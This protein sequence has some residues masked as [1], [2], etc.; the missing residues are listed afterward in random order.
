VAYRI[1]QLKLTGILDQAV[2]IVKDNFGLLFT[3][4]AICWI[5]LQLLSGIIALTMVPTFDGQPT[6]EQ[7]RA[8]DPAQMMIF[9]VV[10]MVLGLVQG[11]IALPLMNAA[12]IY[13]VA[14]KYLGREV[15]AGDALRKGLTKIAPLIGTAIL[16]YLAVFGGLILL[17]IPGILFA[18]WF[19]LSQHT[20]VLENLSGTR[21]LSRSKEL[22]RPNMGTFLMLGILVFVIS[23]L[24]GAGSQMIPQKF[25]AMIVNVLVTSAITLFSIAVFV[26][27]YFSCRCAVENFDLEHLA[28]LIDSG[29]EPTER[30]AGAEA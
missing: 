18:L 29:E 17:I 20:V 14:E 9:G 16:M 11:L 13:A 15:T 23:A 24:A 4:V 26:V 12:V 10:L 3:I 30:I 5:P 25:V 22:V 7:M 2:A 1:Q 8:V 6:P 19:G 27:F 28:A 21:A